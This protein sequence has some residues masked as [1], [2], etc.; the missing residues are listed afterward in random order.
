MNNKHKINKWPLEAKAGLLLTLSAA[1]VI[2]GTLILNDQFEIDSQM[3]S[4]ITINTSTPVLDDPVTETIEVLVKPF[5]VDANIGHYF[6]DM[7]DDLE[8]RSKSIVQVPNKEA[9][10]MKSVGVDYYYDNQF[11]VIAACSG[12]VIERTNDS[13]Y[14]N[15][16]CIEHESGLKTIYSSLDSFNVAKGEEV[17]QGDII[18][19]SGESLF[20]SGLGNSLHFELIKEGEYIN[21]EKSY[22]LEV[23][24]I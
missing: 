13:I 12:I 5:T 7:S 3:S 10:Y 16:L 8:M 23:E 17:Q 11:D 20:T 14:G 2:G 15:L 21:P 9:T 22:T 19:K 4:N 6:Y 24:K 18:A 1:L